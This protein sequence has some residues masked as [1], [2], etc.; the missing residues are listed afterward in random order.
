MEL[1]G[2][3]SGGGGQ[4]NLADLNA[5]LQLKAE[6]DIAFK[7]IARLDL[8]PLMCLSRIRL[9]NR[10]LALIGWSEK[11]VQ[12]CSPPTMARM[13]PSGLTQC[14]LSQN[15]MSRLTVQKKLAAN[16]INYTTSSKLNRGC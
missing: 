10:W 16:H 3:A 12:H 11:T 4:V 8:I 2:N 9:K 13:K 7:A 5:A 6:R 1:E 14:L 15:Q